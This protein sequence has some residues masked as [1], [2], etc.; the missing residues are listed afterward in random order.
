MMIE[1]RSQSSDGTTPYD[2]AERGDRERG[3]TPRIKKGALR[4]MR[5]VDRGGI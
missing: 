3:K 1:L 4:D 5:S 2:V